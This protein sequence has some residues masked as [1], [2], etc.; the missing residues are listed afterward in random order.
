MIGLLKKE[1]NF[2]KLNK[3]IDLKNIYYLNINFRPAMK[4]SQS[5]GV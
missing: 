1:L 3:F 5:F 2:R 4:L